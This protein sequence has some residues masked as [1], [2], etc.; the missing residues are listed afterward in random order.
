MS[1]YVECIAV[2]ACTYVCICMSVYVSVCI[3]ECICERPFFHGGLVRHEDEV[4]AGQA[5]GQGH[6]APVC[7]ELGTLPLCCMT[8]CPLRGSK[9]DWLQPEAAS[10]C[11]SLSL[12]Q[13]HPG[14]VGEAGCLWR[15]VACVDGREWGGSGERE[16]ADQP[17]DSLLHQALS[18]WAYL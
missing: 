1:V 8:A 5:E 14:R 10:C 6:W 17:L 2:Y 4:G 18:V 15:R 9:R 7:Q 3:C 16:H 11:F 13:G 12:Q